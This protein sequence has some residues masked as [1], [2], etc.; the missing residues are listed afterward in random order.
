MAEKMS[1]PTN[2]DIESISRLFF[3]KYRDNR[4]GKNFKYRTGQIKTELMFY[5]RM[6]D[7]SS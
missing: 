7:V 3:S 5:Y 1:L 2:I 6:I 4:I